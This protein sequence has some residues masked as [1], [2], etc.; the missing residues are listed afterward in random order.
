MYY[1]GC[2]SSRN[3][4]SGYINYG[5]SIITN[6]YGEVVARLDDKEATLYYELDFEYLE[7]IREQIPV[8]K[9]TKK[10]DLL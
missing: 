6:P 7:S 8:I 2:A 1:L 9:N 4:S 5:N 3:E 10:H